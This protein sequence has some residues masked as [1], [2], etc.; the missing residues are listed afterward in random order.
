MPVVMDLVVLVVMAVMVVFLV[1]FLVV[2]AYDRSVRS[3][4]M[5]HADTVARSRT[6][7]AA[8]Q[9]IVRPRFVPGQ[10]PVTRQNGA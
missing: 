8:R 6:P 1:V 10:E 5:A 2:V 7:R 9:P 4:E 3:P